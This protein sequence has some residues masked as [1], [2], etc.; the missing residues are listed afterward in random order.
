MPKRLL[1]EGTDIEKLLT[2]VRE[3]HGPQVSIVSADRVRSGGF[4]GFFARQHYELTV[5]VGGDDETVKEPARGVPAKD[6]A[7]DVDPV[8]ALLA[9]TEERERVLSA[10][11]APAQA[12]APSTTPVVPPGFTPAGG[13]TAFAQV[14]AQAAAQ[15]PGAF[16][17]TADAATAAVPAP[18]AAQA[19]AQAQAPAVVDRA[20]ADVLA[21]ERLD[22]AGTYRPA[23]ATAAQAFQ[24]PV[25]EADRPHEEWLRGLGMP[26]HYARRA[27][28]ADRYRAVT[29]ALA[30]MPEAPPVPSRPG[31]VLVIVGTPGT[32]VPLAQTVAKMLNLGP[33]QVLLAARSTAGTGIH[34]ARRVSGPAAAVRRA[35]KM[36]RADLPW[37]VVVD[38]TVE[39]GNG[40]WAREVA[41]A[42]G[43]SAVWAVADATRK[44]AD[45]AAF[46]GTLGPVHG[47]AVTAVAATADPASV[48]G[49]GFPIA[50][51]EDRPCTPQGWAALLCER[52]E[53][54]E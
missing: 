27:T 51:L 16:A 2:Q 35:R 38:A 54:E 37:I 33:S 11:T 34:S 36:H 10:P 52:L 21:A 12:P 6:D 39:E 30:A 17:R 43:A 46:L 19:P 9:R 45:T 47:L 15:V 13:D 48:L 42:L 22:T 4:A 1:L 29:R 5:E 44:T 8:A 53:D 25:V 40:E 31:D 3:E 32:A 14:F 18:V 28:G 23:A 7:A 49:L 24:A 20:F 41:D 26:E 50:Y